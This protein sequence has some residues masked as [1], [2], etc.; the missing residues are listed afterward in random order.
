MS[1]TRDTAGP[2]KR[3]PWRLVAVLVVVALLGTSPPAMRFVTR[4][5][6][7]HPSTGESATPADLGLEFEA[8]ALQAADGTDLHAWWVPRADASGTVLFL[9]G[10][11]GNLSNRVERLR[12]LHDAGLAVLALD[13]RGYGLSSGRPSP[14]GMALDA[15]AAWDHLIGSRSLASSE[16]VVFGSSLGAA[17]ALEL[18]AEIEPARVVLEAPFLSVRAM[19]REVVSILPLSIVPDWH[20]N[21]ATLRRVRAPV[22]VFHG[23][24]DRVVPYEHGRSL[25]ESSERATFYSVEGAGHHVLAP[26]ISAVAFQQFCALLRVDGDS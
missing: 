21:A 26:D 25:A 19:A 10:N 2:Q 17:I 24:A 8:V 13:Y 23:T 11:A 9:H 6:L 16:V 20:D 15:R 7:Y 22:A 14:S 12:H 1:S 4:A 3:S 18:A 5:F